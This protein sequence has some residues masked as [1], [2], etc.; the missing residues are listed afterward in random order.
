MLA[1]IGNF[2]TTGMSLAGRRL[3]LNKR[4]PQIGTF[5]SNVLR[6]GNKKEVVASN[7]L[8][9]PSGITLCMYHR[10]TVTTYSSGKKQYWHQAVLFEVSSGGYTIYHSRTVATYTTGYTLT[11]LNHSGNRQNLS[12]TAV[13]SSCEEDL[14]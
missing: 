11:E 10:R 1:P 8:E 7:N 9:V 13:I 12:Q 6:H 5:T 4:C 14:P 2:L 3:Y